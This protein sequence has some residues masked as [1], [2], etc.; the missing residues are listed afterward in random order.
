MGAVTMK[1]NFS[2]L[3][4]AVVQLQTSIDYL[5]SDQALEDPLLREVLRA[6]TIQAFEF[7]YEL[8][9]KMIRRQLAQIV[10]NPNSLSEIPFAN[11]MRDAA[12][13][14]IIHSAPAY[15]RYR[16]IRNKTSHTYNADKAEE[17]VSVANDFLGDM[18]FLLK[19]LKRLN[20]E[21]D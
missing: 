2:S 12:D 6:G 18:R 1:I 10:P 4:R 7:T 14:G 20:N 16:D 21:T 11:L 8:A 3:E 13:A 17:T 5:N 19:N 9:C 15:I